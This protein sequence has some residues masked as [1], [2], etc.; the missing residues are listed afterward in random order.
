MIPKT[1]HYCWFG[2]KQKPKLIKACISSWKK[3]L[4]GYE[5]L[6]WNERN[7]DLNNPFVREALRLKKWAFVADFVRLKV[8]YENGGIYLDTDMMVIKKFDDLLLNNCFFGKE[9]DNFISA[10]IIGAVK[11]NEFIKRCLFKYENILINNKTDFN[12]IT[13]PIIVT[14]AYKEFLE[15]RLLED[16]KDI[17]VMIYP[18]SYF[19]PFPNKKKYD[20]KNYK[21]YI[22]HLTFAVHL[23]NASWVEY[24]EFDYLKNKQYLKAFLKLCKSIFL[25]NK[26][27]FFYMKKISRH[28]MYSFKRR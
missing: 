9:D 2:N 28:F 18:V 27:S 25:D 5:I 19:Y 22:E 1:I 14:Q 15:G 17:D 12:K 13:M 20:I 11:H 26:M 21:N 23:W 10:G 7:V 8:L 16:F 4:T 3:Y 6:E 24:D